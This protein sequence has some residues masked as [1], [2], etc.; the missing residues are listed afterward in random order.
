MSVTSDRCSL[1][2]SGSR[3]STCCR[4]AQPEPASSR[5]RSAPAA[6]SSASGSDR[7]SRSSMRW[8]SVSPTISRAACS[9]VSSSTTSGCSSAVAETWTASLES[10]GRC[11]RFRSAD[12]T[13]QASSRWPTPSISA[14][15]NQRAVSQSA[16]A[17][18]RASASCQA[19]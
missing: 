16:S 15:R 12:S 17:G 9:P 2:T 3:R 4:P 13:A 11:G 1:S 14:S 19:A 10:A 6:R 8:R 7:S 18:K 5:A